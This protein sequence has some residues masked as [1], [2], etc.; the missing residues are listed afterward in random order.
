MLHDAT[1]L[2][3][4]LKDDSHLQSVVVL[5]VVGREGPRLVLAGLFVVEVVTL[6]ARPTIV[7]QWRRRRQEL[8]MEG[9]TRRRRRVED[10]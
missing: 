7:R 6:V 3:Y 9:G 1:V 10:G 2:L 8:L 4:L 5:L